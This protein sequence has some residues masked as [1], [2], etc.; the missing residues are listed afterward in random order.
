MAKSYSWTIL[1]LVRTDGF[2][3]K[4]VGLTGEACNT[5][6]EYTLFKFQDKIRLGLQVADDSVVVINSEPMKAG[7]RL[8][9][10][11]RRT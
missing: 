10:K 3:N 4:T 7:N 11:T 9:D 1:L 8:E 6:M 5:P 2:N